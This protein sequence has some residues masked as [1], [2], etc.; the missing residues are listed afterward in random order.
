[1]I[2]YNKPFRVSSDSTIRAAETGG[3]AAQGCWNVSGIQAQ[4]LAEM[5]FWAWIYTGSQPHFWK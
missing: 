3:M 4:C 5:E 1:L 2:P